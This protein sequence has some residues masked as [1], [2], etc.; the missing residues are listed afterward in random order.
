[1]ERTMFEVAV[2]DGA[3]CLTLVAGEQRPMSQF[4]N[5]A[6]NLRGP[7]KLQ[8]PMFE[9]AAICFMDTYTHYYKMPMYRLVQCVYTWFHTGF[10]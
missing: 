6:A 5:S 7:Y 2:L 8:M 1:M 9:P 10:L 3:Q 4:W